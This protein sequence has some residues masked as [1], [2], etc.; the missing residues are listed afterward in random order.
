M[1][2]DPDWKQWCAAVA[3]A[4]GPF[5]VFIL[6]AGLWNGDDWI[7]LKQLWILLFSIAGAESLVSVV[8][9]VKN[10]PGS[11][12]RMVYPLTPGAIRHWILALLA[13][14]T[15]QRL[16]SDL[17]VPVGLYN[18]DDDAGVVSYIHLRHLL[19]FYTL[20]AL[21]MIDLFIHIV[22]TVLVLHLRSSASGATPKRMT[23]TI[24]SQLIQ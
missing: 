2:G 15:W 5:V 14:F 9:V 18:G 3:G 20:L 8:G 6:A 13:F 17:D 16:P 12:R 23:T 24:K 10:T 1:T 19:R 7:K 21:C 11:R 22:F 4:F